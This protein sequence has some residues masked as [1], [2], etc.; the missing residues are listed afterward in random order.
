MTG[1]WLKKPLVALCEQSMS[2][3]P[4]RRR[5]LIATA[6]GMIS[7]FL[8]VQS[9]SF[10]GVGVNTSI[11]GAMGF[12]GWVMLLSL[13]WIAVLHLSGDRSEPIS[14]TRKAITI[15]LCGVN[16]LLS[17]LVLAGG[18]VLEALAGSFDGDTFRVF[19]M[20]SAPSFGIAV[21]FGSFAAILCF[22]LW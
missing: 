8:P 18:V 22:S 19:Q 1:S 14:G 7:V 10:A 13:L 3:S 12:V 17:V 11:I 6:I 4:K 15:L 2:I 9:G 5:I 16:L 20:S 21:N